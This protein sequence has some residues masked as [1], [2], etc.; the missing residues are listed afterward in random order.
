M[1]RRTR[2]QP[3]FANGRCSV[4]HAYLLHSSKLIYNLYDLF[5]CEFAYCLLQT[6]R[7]LAQRA[8]REAARA[9]R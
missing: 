8:D 7:P 3:D 9:H 2:V 1:A 4:S 6:T 5:N